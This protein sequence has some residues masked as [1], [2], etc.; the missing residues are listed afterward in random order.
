[1]IS[2]TDKAKDRITNL[3]VEEGKS[4]NHNIR[5][6]VKGAVVRD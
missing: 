4:E 6:S 1:M 3:R 5:V 2:V